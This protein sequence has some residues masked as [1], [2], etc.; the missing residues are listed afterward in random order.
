MCGRYTL[1][2]APELLAEQYDIQSLPPLQSRYNIAP[3]QQVLA[4]RIPPEG[5][6]REGGL[7]R[8]GLIPSW[9]K[10]HKMG[11][12]MI[13]ARAETVGQ[14][15]AFRGPFRHRRCLVV[16]DGFYEWQREGRIKQPFYFQMKDGGPFGFAGL[17]DRWQ[18][19]DGKSV[20]SCTL[21]TTEPNALL[22]PIHHRMPVIIDPRHYADWLDPEAW[23]Q[24]LLQTL[25]RPYPAEKMIGFPVTLRVNNP[26]N[27]DPQCLVPL[28]Q[29]S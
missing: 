7:F 20:E 15:P 21:L 5:S 17:W 16:A 14:K 23:N 18:G 3:G 19:P 11:D 24:N 9:A 13:N 8:W 10:D 4:V 28:A 25:L 6:H 12:R 2:T 27:D 26:R 1:K 29:P 22:G